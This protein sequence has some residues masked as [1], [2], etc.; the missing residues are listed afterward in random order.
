M[1]RRALVFT[2]ALVFGTGTLLWASPR[3]QADQSQ[4]SPATPNSRQQS[5]R[6]QESGESSSRETKVDLAPPKNDAKDHP[7]SAAAVANVEQ[8]EPGDVQELHTWNPHR[9]AKDIEVGDF[10]FRQKN[11]RAALS[12]YKEALQFKPDDALANF[13]IGECFTKLDDPGAAVPYYQEYLKVLPHGPFSKDAEKALAKV[14]KTE[15]VSKD[16]P[17]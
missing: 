17:K 5:D 8:D 9:A 15:D 1:N 10:Y 3:P 4:P 2:L 13:R 7:N 14:E 16:G 12:R 6:L 11:Y